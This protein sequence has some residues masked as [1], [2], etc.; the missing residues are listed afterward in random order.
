[1]NRRL[2]IRH[3]RMVAVVALVT[4]VVLALALTARRPP[5]TREL[6]PVLLRHADPR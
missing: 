1:M 2:R 5:A 3:R 6:A 4:L